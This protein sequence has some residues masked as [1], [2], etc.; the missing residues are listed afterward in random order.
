[1]STGLL[2]TSVV[3]GVNTGFTIHIRECKIYDTDND[4]FPTLCFSLTESSQ[5][6]TSYIDIPVR[7]EEEI[8]KA[9]IL[10]LNCED[11]IKLIVRNAIL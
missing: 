5:L 4:L 8:I 6:P 11:A 7:C 9:H 2:L 3:F 1:M 10:D